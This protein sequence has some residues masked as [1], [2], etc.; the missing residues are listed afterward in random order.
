MISWQSQRNR[1]ESRNTPKAF[2][3]LCIK[4]ANILR[5]NKTRSPV[6][7]D[8]EIDAL[9][10]ERNYKVMDTERV[11]ELVPSMQMIYHF[12]QFPFAIDLGQFL[13]LP[14]CPKRLGQKKALR[15]R[16]CGSVG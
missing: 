1:E 6:S 3:S 14:D 5:I 11:K 15:G 8:G 13:E 16:P 10:T 4:S 12:H 7:S 9:F 2:S